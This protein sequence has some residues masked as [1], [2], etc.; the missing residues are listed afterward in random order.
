MNFFQK[1][2]GS[3]QSP[4]AVSPLEIGLSWL[5]GFLGISLIG[6]INNFVVG[7]QE[8]VLMLASFGASAVLLFGAPKSPLA[9]PRNL[10]GGHIMAAFIGVAVSRILIS[11]P[12]LASALAV[13]TA[14]AVMHLTR[15]LHPPAGATALN[16]VIGGAKVHQLGFVYP[17]VPVAVGVLIL[18]VVALVFNNIPRNRRYPEFWI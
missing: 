10:V 4:P 2:K 17:I 18:L 8:N 15:T 3:G 7:A 1:M 5:G 11:Q 14:I 12:W 6:L 9:Q 16:A 13:A